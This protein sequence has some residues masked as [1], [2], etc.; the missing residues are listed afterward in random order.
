MSVVIVNWNQGHLL[1]GC[2]AA[3][4]VQD[5]VPFEVAGDTLAPEDHPDSFMLIS[6][7][8]QRQKS[9]SCEHCR[10]WQEMKDPQICRTCYWARPEKY[11][12]IAME[13]RRRVEL[14]WVG[15]EVREYQS[16]RRVATRNGLSLAEF[17]KETVRKAVRR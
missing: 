3:L 12:H 8:A 17:I 9:W 1:Q 4:L 2:L 6:A 5:C 16:L 11:E 10:N 15:K 7:A 13:Q 14:V